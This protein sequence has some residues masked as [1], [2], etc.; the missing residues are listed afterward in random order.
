[1]SRMNDYKDFETD[2]PTGGST[3]KFEETGKVPVSGKYKAED[4]FETRS[5]NLGEL[6][7]KGSDQV[8][9]DYGETDPSAKSFIK[10]KPDANGKFIKGIKSDNKAVGGKKI[11]VTFNQETKEYTIGLEAVSS[12]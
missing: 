4:D 3:Q 6:L 7:D 11:V 1:M 12:T 9:A 10:N 2:V 5:V 8:Q